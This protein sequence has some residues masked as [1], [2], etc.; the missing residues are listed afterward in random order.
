MQKLINICGVDCRRG[1][2]KCNG[3]CIGKADRPADRC[4]TPFEAAL[5]EQQLSD[6]DLVTLIADYHYWRVPGTLLTVCALVL[7]NGFTV[8]GEAAC[9]RPELF[10]AGKGDRI[11]Y[12]NAKQKIKPHACYALREKLLAEGVKR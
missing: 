2:A 1:D 5:D 12:E 8:L 9:A 6:G 3:Y 7:K 4:A 11:A 10:D